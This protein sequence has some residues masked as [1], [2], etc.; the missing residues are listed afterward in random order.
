MDNL[1]TINSRR[2]I[3]LSKS[4]YDLPL[5]LKYQFILMLPE[6]VLSNDV[7]HEVLVQSIIQH[8]PPESKKQCPIQRERKLSKIA[9][10]ADEIYERERLSNA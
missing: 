9:R 4:F 8:S 2:Q 3:K 6:E 1:W 5:Y 10:A 7:S